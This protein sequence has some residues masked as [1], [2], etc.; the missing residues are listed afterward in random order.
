M[1]LGDFKVGDSGAGV[2]DLQNALLALGY[3][4]GQD[5]AGSGSFGPNTDSAVRA[6]QGMAGLPA[7]G[8]ADV[9]TLI[10][11]GS[12]LAGEGPGAY[13]P[14]VAPGGAAVAVMPT[15]EGGP[16]GS[17]YV[18]E[19]GLP[20]LYA[21]EE[22]VVAPYRHWRMPTWGWYAIGAAA[23]WYFFLRKPRAA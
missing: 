1:T 2:V 18:D 3:D 4:V 16:E 23:V 15:A 21:P 9:P 20:V 10:A 19:N 7:T 22:T 6:F 11:M 14:A 5:E 8:V 13:A 12:A 17:A